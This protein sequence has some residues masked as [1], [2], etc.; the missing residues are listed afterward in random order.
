[1]QISRATGEAKKQREC[2]SQREAGELEC[3]E[4]IPSRERDAG[5][6]REQ[7]DEQSK[8]DDQRLPISKLSARPRLAEARLH[9]P[10]DHIPKVEIHRDGHV[11]V[12]DDQAAPKNQEQPCGRNVSLE[13]LFKW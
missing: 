7:V 4:S 1:E 5:N 13:C 2:E 6:G 12:A 3:V 8:L 10:H 11:C 9:H